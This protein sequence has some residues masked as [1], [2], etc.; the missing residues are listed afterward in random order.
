M[1]NHS[2]ILIRITTRERLKQMGKKGQTYEE[3]IDRLLRHNENKKDSLEGR[4][5]DL[6]SSESGG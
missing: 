4:F 3:I 1:G 6:Q 5:G 2:T